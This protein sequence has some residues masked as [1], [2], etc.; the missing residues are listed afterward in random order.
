ML[1]AERDFV[2]AWHGYD[3][4]TVVSVPLC[5]TEQEWKKY[6]IA[7]KYSVIINSNGRKYFDDADARKFACLDCPIKFQEAMMKQGLCKPLKWRFTP[8]ARNW[9]TKKKEL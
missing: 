3:L 8:Y 2:T 9:Q 7:A 1:N 6:Y 5:F 4:E